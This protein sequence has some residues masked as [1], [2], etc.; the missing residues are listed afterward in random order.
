MDV[1]SYLAKQYPFPPCWS[2]VADVL[3]TEK[4]RTVNDYKA[5]NS[6][7]RAIAGA[8]RLILHKSA[9]G[10]A[11]IAEPVDYCVVL[12]GR[13]EKMGLHHCGIYYQGRVL[14]AIDSCNQYQEMSVISDEYE[15]IEFWDKDEN[16][17]I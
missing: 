14:H 2:M 8:L 11:Q 13:S 12:M 4:G 15:L 6:G 3:M 1:N 5:I 7:I 10:F 9:H 17:I 16:T